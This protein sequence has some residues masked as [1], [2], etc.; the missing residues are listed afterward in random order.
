LEVS[1]AGAIRGGFDT[2]YPIVRERHGAASRDYGAIFFRVDLAA[3]VTKFIDETEKNLA[4]VFAE[5]GTT[6]AIL[7]FDEDDATWKTQQHEGCA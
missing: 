2:E 5:A 4:D 6:D 1:Y 3:A 7:M